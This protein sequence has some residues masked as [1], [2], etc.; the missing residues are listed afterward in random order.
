MFSEEAVLPDHPVQHV[1]A[2]HQHHHHHRRLYRHRRQRSS[3]CRSPANPD[4]H[5]QTTV[6]IKGERIADRRNSNGAFSAASRSPFIPSF[7]SLVK[8]HDWRGIKLSRAHVSA[9]RRAKSTFERLNPITQTRPKARTSK[10]AL[11]RLENE[12]RRSLL[13]PFVGHPAT[14]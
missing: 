4:L 9:G 12:N 6:C 1:F 7:R 2:H 8:A 13:L 10:L 5:S 11:A 14:D 3:F